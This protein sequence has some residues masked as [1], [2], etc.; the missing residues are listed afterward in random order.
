MVDLAKEAFNTHNYDLAAEIYERSIKDRGPNIEVFLGLADSL[1]GTGDFSKAFTA[2]TQALRLGSVTPERLKHLVSFLVDMMGKNDKLMPQAAKDVDRD[3]FRCH[4]CMGFFVNPLTIPCGHTFC[5]KCLEKRQSKQCKK[6]DETHHFLNIRSIKNN[7][8]ISKMID[9]LFSTE[10]NASR[11]KE[12]ANCAIKTRKFK[13]AADIYTQAL[14]HA[15]NDHVLASNRAHAYISMGMFK[16]ALADADK[17]IALKPDWPKGYYRRATALSEMFRLQEASLAYLQCLTLDPSAD[18]ARNCLAKTL[19]KVLQPL[20]QEHIKLSELNLNPT[21]FTSSYSTTEGATAEPLGTN[22]FTKETLEQLKLKLK[23]KILQSSYAELVENQESKNTSQNE[24]ACS[25]D[26]ETTPSK[27]ETDNQSEHSPILPKCSHSPSEESKVPNSPQR[28]KRNISENSDYRRVSDLVSPTR[29]GP[30]KKGKQGSPPSPTTSR[31]GSTTTFET[32]FHKCLTKDD[33][34]CGLCFRLLYEPVTTP[35][36]HVFCKQ[37]LDR[38]LDHNT[39]CPACRSCLAEYLAARRDSTTEVVN[40][41]VQKYYPEEYAERKEV[42]EAEMLEYAGLVEEEKVKIPIFVCT[43]SY[44]KI[45]CPLHIFEPRYRLMVR[46][47]MEAGTR[48]FG[49]TVANGPEEDDFADFGCMLEIRDVQFFPDGRSVVDC[50]GGRRFHVKSKGMRDGY[51]TAEVEFIQD[52]K[53]QGPEAEELKKIHDK[54]YVEVKKWISSLSARQMAQI[55]SHFGTM[56]EPD[57][58]PQLLDNGPTWAWW[59][60]GVLPLNPAAQIKILAMQSLKERLLAMRKI[61]KCV[62]EKQ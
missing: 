45:P 47:A 6:C 57:N 32:K 58:D 38:C 50:I 42:F 16:E 26:A 48:Q 23:E 60:L 37:C 41:V 29:P 31:R 62:K 53:V 7:I 11:L 5:R 12:Q 13:E 20:P 22:I 52:I 54:M 30:S 59:I 25:Q 46:Q 56:P 17:A 34:E 15:P 61:L 44:P 2:Y 24:S 28:R 9:L 35:C 19:H 18:T 51:N 49:M 55:T 1:A 39:S 10:M 8:L 43:V 3:L 40:E 21:H 36:G 4:L 27:C 33:F 14:E